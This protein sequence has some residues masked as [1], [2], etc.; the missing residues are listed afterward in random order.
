MEHLWRRPISRR[1]T[2]AI[3]GGAATALVT[4]RLRAAEPPRLFEWRGSALGAEATIRL[5][6]RSTAQAA[7]A[8]DAAAAEI[9]RLENE[10][11]SIGRPRRYPGSTAIAA[12]LVLRSICASSWRR[13]SA[14]AKRA[15]APSM[16]PCSRYG[17]STRDIF[18]AIPMT[19]RGRALN[20]WRE[21]S[22]SSIT[23][24]SRSNLIGSCF[25]RAWR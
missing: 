24:G 10:F 22:V 21:R 17:S 16:L 1:R 18:L 19:V 25:R 12:C 14:S 3:F 5:Y 23:V 6:A 15:K 20:S 11:S 9:E 4:S 2:L 7:E 13:P 8:L